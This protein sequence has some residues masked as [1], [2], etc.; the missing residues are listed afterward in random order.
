M[1]H[2]TNY[3]NTFIEVAEDCPALS[4]EIPP[5]KGEA[6]TVANLQ[7]E[8]IAENP[9]TFTSDEVIFKVLHSKTSLVATWN[10]N[11]K[12]I[13]PK[14][15]LVCGHPRL[16]NGM[17]GAFTTIRKGRWLCSR[18]ILKNTNVLSKTLP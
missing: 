1:I 5:Q 12:R 15:R 2:T 13:S 14:A 18:W 17:A 9:Y 7:F 6:K 4:A 8:L 3:Y 16:P 10:K 11:G